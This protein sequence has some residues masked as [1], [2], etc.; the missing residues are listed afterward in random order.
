L[1][2]IE[3]NQLPVL[4]T[5]RSEQHY[6]DMEPDSIELMTEGTLT[7]TG[8]GGMVL[9]YQESELTGLEGTTTAFE[10]RGAQVILTRTGSVN[11]QMV[12]EEGKQH[13]SL[14]ETPFGELAID[15]QTSRL[16]HSLTERGGLLDLQY[17][18]SVD[19]SVT[20]RNAFKIRVKRK[21][22]ARANGQS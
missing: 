8:E 19:H 9:S 10:I 16:R 4:L 12:F 15:I 7:L 14:Y 1:I 21:H 17:S 18:I 5:I 13:T 2:N 11:S 3:K 6:E 22:E 20:G